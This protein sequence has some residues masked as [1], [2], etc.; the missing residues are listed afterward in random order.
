MLLNV[1]NII[2]NI[3]NLVL[4]VVVIFLSLRIVLNLF[5][6]NST[7]PFVQ[8]IYAISSN[9]VYPFSG[10]VPNITLGTNS[11][12]DIVAFIAI[13]AY[14]LVTYLIIALVD[15]ITRHTNTGYNDHTVHA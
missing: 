13:I 6:A 5:A 3:L 10:I 4:A 11:V 2:V 1:R 8:W 14:T 12:L 9:F 7:T 15:A